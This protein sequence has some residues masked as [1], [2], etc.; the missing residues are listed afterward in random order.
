MEISILMYA[1][2]AIIPGMSLADARN[3]LQLAKTSN[4]IHLTWLTSPFMSSCCSK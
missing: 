2:R 3:S 1:K 4:G